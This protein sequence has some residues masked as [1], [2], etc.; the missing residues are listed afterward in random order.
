MTRART[1]LWEIWLRYFGVTLYTAWFIFM[2][3]MYIQDL[4]VCLT[5]GTAPKTPLPCGCPASLTTQQWSL[6]TNCLRR[7]A[8]PYRAAVWLTQSCISRSWSTARATSLTCGN[9]VT[10]CGSHN[11]LACVFREITCPWCSSSR[12]LDLI[13]TKVSLYCCWH[14]LCFRYH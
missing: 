1:A 6:H 11:I 4:K 9:S 13:W 5:L 8:P 10:D 2:H 3:L 12:P 14:F 7:M